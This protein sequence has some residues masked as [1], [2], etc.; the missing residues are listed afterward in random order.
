MAKKLELTP[1]LQLLADWVPQGAK[2]ADIGTD[3]G[4][5]PV[6]LDLQGRVV[7]AVASDLRKG[8]L[9]RAKE[10]GRIYGAEHIDYRLGNGLEGVFPEEADVIVIAGMNKVEDTLEAAINRART[11][12]APMNKQRFPNQTPCEVTGKCGDCKA[13]GCICNQIL[14]TRNCNPA[15]RIKIILVGEELGL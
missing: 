15:G 5:L 11:V 13:E 9:E 7:S 14:V 12:A 8:P 1:R 4:F 10:T 3:H 6:W 2:L